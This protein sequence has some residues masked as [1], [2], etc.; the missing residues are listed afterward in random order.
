MAFKKN[1]AVTG[2]TI[3]LVSA[4]NGSAV[5]TGTPVGYV[6]IDGGTQT[7]IADVT[8]VHE[9]NGQYSFNLTAAETNGNIIGLTF[10]DSASL[11]VYYTIKTETKLTSDLLDF[12]AAL[13]TVASVTLVGTCTSNTDMRGTTGA[14]TI[15]PDNNSI[16]AILAD[17]NELQL[18]QGNWTTATGF[19][20]FNPALDTVATVTNLTNLPSIPV[21]WITSTGIA[22]AALNGKGNWNLGKTG[23]SI[24]GTKTTLDSLSDLT[25]AQ[26]WE[27]DVSTTTAGINKAGNV[28]Q[29]I[30][31]DTTT[32]I[33]ALISALN[34]LSSTQIKAAVLLALQ[35]PTT[36]PTTI[37]AATASIIDKLSY[38]FA[39][40]GNK[41]NQTATAQT[42]RNRTDTLNISSAVVS[43]DGT[44]TSRGTHA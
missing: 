43:S 17:T 8:P 9:G 2:L 5:T 33:P 32:D 13:D 25:A 7:A 20:T 42:L 10:I 18:N 39:Y 23:Y 30:A 28:V 4:T 1:T 14:N 44:T 36:E 12:N 19:S 35:D 34:N 16:T 3:G 41:I 37:P 38:L 24:Q 15:A 31:T 6:T 22:A 27:H 11:P 21:N 26:I 40:R 29:T